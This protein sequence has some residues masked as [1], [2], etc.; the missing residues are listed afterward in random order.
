MCDLA[1]HVGLLKSSRI[2]F[3][4]SDL[5]CSGF[6]GGALCMPEFPVVF[7]CSRDRI[8][9]LIA[10][11][12]ENIFSQFFVLELIS[13]LLGKIVYQNLF[14]HLCSREK[15]FSRLLKKCPD[16]LLRI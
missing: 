14:D 15:S 12:G 6:A 13:V 2:K 8:P 1:L 11:A 16:K 7:E 3:E 4:P 5:Y 10:L 9:K